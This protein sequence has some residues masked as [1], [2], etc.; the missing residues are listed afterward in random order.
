MKEKNVLYKNLVVLIPVSTISILITLSYVYITISNKLNTPDLEKILDSISGFSSLLALLWLIATV[1]LQSRAI[2]LQHEE[3]IKSSNSNSIQISIQTKIYIRSRLKESESI[4]NHKNEAARR[5]CLEMA[6]KYGNVVYSSE[7]YNNPGYF[8]PDIVFYFIDHNFKVSEIDPNKGLIGVIEN[9]DD[10]DIRSDFKYEAL[11]DLKVLILNIDEVWRANK[12]IFYDAEE[13]GLGKETEA[14]INELS[15]SW[16]RENYLILNALDKRI[17]KYVATHEGYTGIQTFMAQL[18]SSK[19]D[20][21]ST[22]EIPFM[23]EQSE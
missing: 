8:M 4:I 16:Y 9:L 5:L 19:E 20:E 23:M 10:K 7:A 12:Q 11:S 18:S 3:M 1:I 2:K 21:V 14:W 6:K 13:F 15:I 22:V 17:T